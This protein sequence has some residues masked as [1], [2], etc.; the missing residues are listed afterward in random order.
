[1][2][3]ISAKGTVPRMYKKHILLN[4]EETQNQTQVWAQDFI[5]HFNKEDI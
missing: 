1:M 3:Y 2:N 4:S 5:T